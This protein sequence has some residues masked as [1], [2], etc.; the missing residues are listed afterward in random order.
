MLRLAATLRATDEVALACPGSGQ[1]ANA[2]RRMGI[3]VFS[4]PEASASLRV[5]L[6]RTPSGISQLVGQGIALAKAAR[7][8]S[9]DLILETGQTCP[10][11]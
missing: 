11:L 1:L 6:A 8:F 10:K 4:V 2:A 9:A 7:R 3:E 5:G